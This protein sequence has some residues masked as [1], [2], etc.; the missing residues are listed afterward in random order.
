MN[1]LFR[2]SLTTEPFQKLN[3]ATFIDGKLLNI[4]FW[5]IDN[6]TISVMY[7]ALFQLIQPQLKQTRWNTPFFMYKCIEIR[8]IWSF[9]Q[10]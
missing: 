4:I 9:D 6:Q 3:T 5:S 10:W 8:K 7:F 1:F 2:T